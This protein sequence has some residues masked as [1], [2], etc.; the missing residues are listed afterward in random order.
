VLGEKEVRVFAD[1]VPNR[2]IFPDKQ[3][4]A[5]V[6][7]DSS[8][9]TEE[10]IQNRVDI[11]LASAQF[12]ARGAGVLGSIQVENGLLTTLVNFIDQV[13][14]SS[15][16]IDAIRAIADGDTYAAGPMKLR[17]VALRDG[18]VVFDTSS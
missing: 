1:V 6:S 9:M 17:L 18:E 10:D 5:A 16:S 11:L 13:K 2:Q 4:I 12:R 14:R 8:S 7:I 15:T 3:V